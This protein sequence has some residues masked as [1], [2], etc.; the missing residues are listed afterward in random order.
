MTEMGGGAR[1]EARSA[2]GLS[3]SMNG[4]PRKGEPLPNPVAV[5]PKSPR[6]GELIFPRVSRIYPTKRESPEERNL[7]G[8]TRLEEM[9]AKLSQG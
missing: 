9:T 6:G 1:A 2:N 7:Q 5:V 8:R 4:D 3:S